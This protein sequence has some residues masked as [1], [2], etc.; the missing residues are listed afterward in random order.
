MRPR[1]GFVSAG[2]SAGLVEPADA[3][4]SRYLIMLAAGA[5]A[6]AM[7]PRQRQQSP[8]SAY[9][10]AS[11]VVTLLAM[12]VIAHA[13]E[14]LPGWRWACRS[15]GAAAPTTATIIIRPFAPTA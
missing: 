1:R 8:L 2:A 14:P 6:A 3:F 10:S 11:A 7:P 5:G 13:A 12:L 15:T 4:W 9:A